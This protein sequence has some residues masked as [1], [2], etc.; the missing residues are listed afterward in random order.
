MA[1]IKIQTI[2]GKLEDLGIEQKPSYENFHFRE[3]ALSGYWIGTS[4]YDSEE[5]VITF[6]VGNETF[7]CKYT[8]ENIRLL[9]SILSK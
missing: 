2:N 9:E 4:K 5:R 8:E 7:I 1:Q 3:S 6:Y